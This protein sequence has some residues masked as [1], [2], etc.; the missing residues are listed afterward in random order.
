[1]RA[2]IFVFIAFIALL[3]GKVTVGLDRLMDESSYHSWIAG[4]NVGLISNT[5]G[6][7][8]GQKLSA[9]R[10]LEGT[11][12]TL[13]AIFAPEHGFDGRLHASEK[14]SDELFAGKIP[15]HSLHGRSRRPSDEMLKGLDLVIF[16]VQDIGCRSYT[17][18]STLFYMMEEASKRNI[19]VIVADRPNPMGGHLVD[20]LALD[21]Q[22]RSFVGYIDVPY[23]HG[24]TVGE[25][26]LY[27]NQEYKIGCDL[28]V[29]PMSGW[30]RSMKFTDTGLVWIPTSPN[31][32]EP[33]TPLFYT[34]CGVV[35]ELN[36]INNGV[37]Y[38]MP[39]KV[40]GAPWI[41]AA[42]LS[43]SLNKQ[44]FP[45]VSFVPIHYKP[46]YGSFKNQECHGVKVIV[47]NPSKI[48]PVQTQFLIIGMIKSLYPQEFKKAMDKVNKESF[49]KIA[50]HEQVYHILKK[51]RYAIYKLK[52][53][54]QEGRKAFLEKRKPYLI[55]EYKS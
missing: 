30:K 20:G 10:L 47:N 28:K 5:T 42:S 12:F 53:L 32:P 50:G 25:L 17:Y 34:M 48:L 24:M 37:G 52:S 18:I 16:D 3:E 43:S 6:L 39:F 45:G 41:D 9:D 8:K 36:L 31:I 4:K 40:V 55:K 23:C 51:E 14:V 35:G 22:C 11:D 19:T 38:T 21:N 29:V 54:C 49:C 27:F 26:A 33:D 2:F 13:V 44:G 1:M 46:F 7:C 15:I